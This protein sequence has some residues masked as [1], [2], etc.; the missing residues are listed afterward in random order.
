VDFNAQPLFFKISEE[1][2]IVKILNCDKESVAT[3]STSGLTAANVVQDY[4]DL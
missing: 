3:V 2:G 1:L 4:R